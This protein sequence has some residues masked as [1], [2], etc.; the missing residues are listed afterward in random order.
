MGNLLSGKSPGNSVNQLATS[1]STANPLAA[2][3]IVNRTNNVKPSVNPL[4][5]KTN[6][7]NSLAVKGGGKRRKNKSKRKIKNK[8]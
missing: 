7:A 2:K 5:A 3:T 4:A 1:T 8:K 6:T